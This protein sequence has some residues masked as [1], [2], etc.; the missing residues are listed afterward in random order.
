MSFRLRS[1]LPMLASTLVACV[2]AAAAPDSGDGSRQVGPFEINARVRSIGDSGRF[3]R[4]G[5]PFGSRTVREYEVRWNSRPVELPVIGKRFWQALH[6]PD[7]P[8]PTLLVVNGPRLHLVVDGGGRLD[9]RALAPDS[10]NFAVQ[11]LDSADGQPAA[12]VA[13]LG[14]DRADDAPRTTLSGGRWLYLNNRLLL[15]LRTL[16]TVP[17]EPWLH[18]GQGETVINMNASNS[19]AVALS[20]G[21]TR[22]VLR[23]E[24]QDYGRGGERFD[25]LL[26]IDLATGKPEALRLDPKRTPY[27]D[28]DAIDAAWIATHLQWTRGPDGRERLQPR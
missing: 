1:V 28:L 2:A 27:G 6:L 18:H 13:G 22:F 8:Q 10:G 9:I 4:S 3:L 23:G 5:N 25:L 20:P 11:W 12:P 21:R 24:G 17:V 14:L 15:D 26:V 16:A 7:A 19:P